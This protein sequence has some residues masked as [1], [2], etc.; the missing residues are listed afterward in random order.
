MGVAVGTLAMVVMAVTAATAGAIVM[1]AMAGAIVM[2]ATAGMVAAV[3][4]AIAW[5]DGELRTM[6]A[7]AIKALLS[8]LLTLE[9]KADFQVVC[10]LAAEAAVPASAVEA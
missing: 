3:A 9:P 2:V 1:V 5:T 7:V 6:V 8:L 4:V 10:R